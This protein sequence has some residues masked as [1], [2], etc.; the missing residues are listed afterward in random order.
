[1]MSTAT[2]IPLQQVQAHR[3]WATERRL[4]RYVAEHRIRY[5]KIDGRILFDLHDLDEYAAAGRI[6]PA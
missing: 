5:F 2:L 4:R 3:P 1:M 6:D